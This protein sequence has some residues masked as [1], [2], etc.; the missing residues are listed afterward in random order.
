MAPLLSSGDNEQG[1]AGVN[2]GRS[3]YAVAASRGHAERRPGEDEAAATRRAEV[4]HRT[5]VSGRLSGW[6]TVFD[7]REGAR[8]YHSGIWNLR[9][10]AQGFWRV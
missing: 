6:C 7:H 10:G 2:A 1:A 9:L 8:V 4:V 3:P 5:L